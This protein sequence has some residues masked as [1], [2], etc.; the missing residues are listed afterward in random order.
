MRDSEG[1]R[2]EISRKTVRPPTPESKTPIG[3]PLLSFAISRY[4]HAASLALDV[5]LLD[6]LVEIRARRIDRFSGLRDVPSVFAQF[7]ENERLL[8]FVLELL[9][10][11][12]AHAA[13][14]DV[15]RRTEELSR[16]IGDVDR[17]RGHHDD[18]PL[19]E[20]ADLADVPA[21]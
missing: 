2:R 20:I 9:E 6:L 10:R 14:D 18:Q 13:G 21:P 12:E 5:V 7:R 11:V 17:I 16:Q 4:H 8:R 3:R 19:D 15:G 1:R